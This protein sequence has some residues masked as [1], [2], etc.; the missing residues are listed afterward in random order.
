MVVLPDADVEM[1]ADAAVA[2]PSAR[3]ASAAWRVG[4]GRGRRPP[5]RSSPR[6]SRSGC[7]SSDPWA[8]GMDPDLGDGAARHRASTA[9]GPWLPRRRPRAGRGGR[10]DGR[11]LEVRTAAGS[12]WASRSSTTWTEDM[13]IY[14]DEIFGPVLSVVR[15]E[16]YDEA[17]RLANENPYG[18]GV[19]LFTR[20]GGAAANSSSRCRRAWSGSTS[21]SRCRSRTTRS[22][23]GRRPSSATR[24]S[25]DR[26]A[27]LLHARQGRHEPLARPGDEQG[28]PRLPPDVGA[29]PSAITGC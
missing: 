14:R 21:R 12:S 18:N 15:A 28:R 22:A 1:A 26:R 5:T 27:S 19:A 3:R 25:T 2:P 7:R 4:G 8:D 6:S 23:A 10:A 9:T 13:S 16:S 11:G 17:V 29:S 20:D 24:T